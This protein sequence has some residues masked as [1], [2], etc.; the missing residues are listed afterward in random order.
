MKFFWGVPARAPP[1]VE[2]I[3][4]PQAR[5][6]KTLIRREGRKAAFRVRIG[7]T[8]TNVRKH[9]LGAWGGGGNVDDVND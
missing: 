3:K 9:E 5:R 4:V 6:R 2:G 8:Y 7:S 1:A